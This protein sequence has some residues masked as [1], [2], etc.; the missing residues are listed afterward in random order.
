[1]PLTHQMFAEHLWISQDIPEL[2]VVSHDFQENAYNRDKS[3]TLDLQEQ[4]SPTVLKY[5]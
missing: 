5:K 1:M 4:R 3:D 2:M